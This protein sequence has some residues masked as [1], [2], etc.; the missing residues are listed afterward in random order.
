MQR[1]DYI[2]NSSCDGV[3]ADVLGCFYDNIVYTPFIHIED[4]VDL[5]NITS[6]KRTPRTFTSYS[7]NTASYKSCPLDQDQ[8]LSCPML[9]KR[10]PS[11]PQ[12]VSSKCRSQKLESCG[13]RTQRRRRHDRLGKN[14]ALFLRGQDCLFSETLL[15]RRT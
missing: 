15:G 8:K 1:P 13:E 12:L 10:T 2:K 4:E 11:A 6:K 9:P 7:P 3:S 14:G 5:K